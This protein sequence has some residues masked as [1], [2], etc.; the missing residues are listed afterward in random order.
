MSAN[1]RIVSHC[2]GSERK[3]NL[4]TDLKVTAPNLLSICLFHLSSC[5]L[6]STIAPKDF[7]AQY[8][9]RRYTAVRA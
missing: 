5:C 9:S 2:E 3:N 7:S 1:H 4:S 6:L 8:F